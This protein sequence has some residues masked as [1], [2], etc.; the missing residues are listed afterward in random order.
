MYPFTKQLIEYKYDHPKEKIGMLILDVKGNFYKQVQKY[1][2]MFNRENDLIVLE[3]GGELKYNPL[4]K[5][6]LKANLLA[7]RLKTILTLFSPNNQES[8]WLDKTE[9]VLTEAI[10]FCRLYNNGYVTFSEIHKLINEPDY[11]REKIE[12]LRELFTSNAFNQSDIY[13]LLSA[14]NFFEKE[15][16]SLDSKVLSILKS[17]INRITLTFISDFDILNTFSPKESELNFHGFSE[18]LSEG[19]IVV[20]NMNISEYRNLSKIIAS[21]LKL[22]FQ[23]E[24]LS[25]INKSGFNRTTAFICDEFQEYVTLADSDFFAIRKRSKMYQYCCNAKLYLHSKHFKRS[26]LHKIYNTEFN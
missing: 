1:T 16:N 5:P 15:F 6:N 11:Y 20:L 18:V 8:Y 7:N 17:E 25:S 13:N 22:D 21:Y 19:K 24:V 23:G 10:K 2:E 3:L 9:Q 4:H 26:I 14:I 12:L